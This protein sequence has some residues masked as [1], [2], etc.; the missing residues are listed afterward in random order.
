MAA[1]PSSPLSP[2]APDVEILFESYLQKTPPLDKLF[3]KW[4]K[5]WFVLSRTNPHDP[6]SIDLS[7]Y[8]DRTMKEKRGTI[9]L[10]KFIGIRPNAK[11][12]HK[13]NVF[14]IETQE[15]KF[16]LRASD[17]RTKNIWLAKLCEFCGQ[18]PVYHVHIPT[19]PSAES[20]EGIF[21]FNSRGSISIISPSD[22]HS[23]LEVPLKDI[24]RVGSMLI[25]NRDILWIETCRS[26]KNSSELDQF[27][28]FVISS[29]AYARQSLVRELKI[30]TEKATGVFL[31][32]EETSPTEMAYI[33]R[34][35]YGCPSFPVMARNRILYGGLIPSGATLHSLM[36]AGDVLRRPSEPIMNVGV[37]LEEIAT[38]PSRRGTIGSSPTTP[39]PPGRPV[40][41]RGPTS[42]DRFRK[43]SLTSMSSQNSTD[44]TG[45]EEVH[46]P[47]S[48][49]V[50][51]P[52]VLSPLKRKL[53]QKDS[54][55][56]HGSST[57][58]QPI[59]EDEELSLSNS[60]RLSKSRPDLHRPNVPPRS[61]ASLK[62][63][64]TTPSAL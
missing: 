7:Y 56:S 32:L 22:S 33:S 39:Y 30:M 2:L 10:A 46:T 20:G 54:L 35:H 21:K 38:K 1:S 47:L 8:N 62:L 45:S 64:S 36:A 4:K 15:R 55:S 6:N 26:C 31:I 51:D 53:S 23:L 19:Q 37:S 18:E 14:A 13:E 9:N 63:R 61:P 49:G 28:F 24:R 11:I 44:G 42:L 27:I 43:P 3:V 40:L 48:D 57:G 12:G 50:F 5:R 41:S 34:S 29:G 60:R 16:I 59:P 58:S 52:P 17:Q 25:N